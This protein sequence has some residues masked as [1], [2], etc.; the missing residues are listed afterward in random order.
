MTLVGIFGINWD[1]I[2]INDNKNVKFLHKN[3]VNIALE[4]GKSI[5]KTKKHD[6]G[7][8]ITILHSESCFSLVI[9]LNSH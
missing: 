1:V 5:K 8:E 6:L 9:F 4:A 3:F 7:L 2:K